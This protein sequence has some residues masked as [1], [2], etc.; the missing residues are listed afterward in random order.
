MVVR[1]GDSGCWGWGG[2]CR[3]VAGVARDVAGVARGMAGRGGGCSNLLG[4]A[5]RLH[6]RLGTD[7]VAAES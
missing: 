5:C 6:R 4:H 7:M 1:I 2:M 3:D